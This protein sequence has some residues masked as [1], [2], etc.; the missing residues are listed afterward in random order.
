MIYDTIIVGAGTAGMTA[1]L[2]LRRN[3][4]TVLLLEEENIGGQISFSPR[5][6]NIPA[7]TEIAGSKFSDQLFSQVLEL[8]AEVEL[9]K[10]IKVNKENDL[11]VVTTDYN[12]YSSR[13]IIIA[14]GVQHRH[15]RLPKEQELIGH[16]VSY[17]ALCDGA[18]YKNQEVVLIG[19]GNTALQ[20][21]IL[22]TN[23]CPKVYVCTLFDKFFG[24]DALV[25]TL[26]AKENIEIISNVSAC[27]FLGEE[28]LTGIVFQRLD[29]SKFQLDVPA[30]FVAIGQVPNNKIF[31]DFV[32]LD[33]EGYIVTDEN[34]ATTTDGMYAI[35][36]CRQK[37][38]RQLTTAMADGAVA[39]FNISTF[40]DSKNN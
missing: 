12:K 5:V 24:D 25:R 30:V 13:A 18:F 19:D 3:N 36:D 20:Y 4:K 40:I 21:A 17:C 28:E 23:Y 11:F 32:E 15:L 22:M 35:G 8:G 39:A 33:K 14:T 1:A 16:G 34:C 27:E 6:E 37:P 26:K 31:T 7:I 10:A 9:E 2:N 29:K 38:V